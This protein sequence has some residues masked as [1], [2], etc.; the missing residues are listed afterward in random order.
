M[1]FRVGTNPPLIT[2]YCRRC[3]MPVERFQMDV[4]KSPFYVGIHAQCCGYTQSSRVS[5]DEVF[6]LQRTNDKFYAVVPP[7]FD[8][9]IKTQARR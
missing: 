8:Q 2:P 5:I 4:V 9:G 3:D 7:Q 1:I 6:R